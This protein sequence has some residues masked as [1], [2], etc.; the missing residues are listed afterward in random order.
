M[1]FAAA[2]AIAQKTN[3]NH[4]PYV[5]QMRIAGAKGILLRHPADNCDDPTIDPEE[6]TILL[7]PSQMKIHMLNPDRSQLTMDLVRGPLCSFPA[8]LSAEV[9]VNLSHNGVPDQVFVDLMKEGLEKEVKRLTTWTGNHSM[10][11]LFDAVFT[12]QGVSQ[13]RMRLLLGAL[14]RARGYGED[15]SD[16]ALDTEEEDDEG[17]DPVAWTPDEISGQPSSLPEAVMAFLA[18]GFRPDSLPVLMDKLKQ[19]LRITMEAYVL[20]YKISVPGSCTAFVAPGM[21]S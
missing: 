19:I 21:H 15:E 5:V 1:N 3:R 11:Q 17:D 12:S 18:S 2:E 14:A 13:S 6:P 20:K 16:D 4:V 8:K 9:I 7:R 10:K